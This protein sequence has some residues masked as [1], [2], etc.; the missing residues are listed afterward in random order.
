MRKLPCQKAS[1]RNSFRHIFYI[2]HRFFSATADDETF[3]RQTAL[4]DFLD[5]IFQRL[6]VA[7][8]KRI[9][10]IK[11][12]ENVRK[13]PVAEFQDRVIH[14]EHR[15]VR[16]RDRFRFGR[17]AQFPV[18]VLARFNGSA[19]K[20]RFDFQ[21]AIRPVDLNFGSG[22]ALD[23][24]RFVTAWPNEINRDGCVGRVLFFIGSSIRPALPES[25]TNNV[26]RIWSVSTDTHAI[27]P[28]GA[29][30]DNAALSPGLNEPF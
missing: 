1:V 22:E 13:L 6:V 18:H 7:N 8:G 29:W 26:S 16:V 20:M 10:R 11:I 30:I 3:L 5:V 4:G 14:C 27:P 25:G 2:R 17:H 19:G 15:Q 9:S 12:F 23:R 28:N 24:Q 21:L